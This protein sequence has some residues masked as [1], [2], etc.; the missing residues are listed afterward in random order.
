MKKHDILIFFVGFVLFGFLRVDAQVAV[1]K[2]VTL[3]L[4]KKIAGAGEV[5]AKK[6]SDTCGPGHSAN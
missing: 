2:A 5:E 1:K 3:E 4:A 6:N